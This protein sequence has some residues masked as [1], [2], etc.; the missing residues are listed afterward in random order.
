MPISTPPD[1]S[2]WLGCSLSQAQGRQDCDPHHAPPQDSVDRAYFA[3]FDGHGGVDAARY[4]SV[5][6]HAVAAHRPELPTDPTGALR[7]AFRC[8]DEMFL[9]KARREVRT[10]VGPEGPGLAEGRKPK[11]LVLAEGPRSTLLAVVSFHSC[12]EGGLNRSSVRL[13]PLQQRV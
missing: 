7:A 3:V 9:W 12:L 2:L 8:T 10:A 11:W 13:P 6:V 1:Q 4:A 5:H